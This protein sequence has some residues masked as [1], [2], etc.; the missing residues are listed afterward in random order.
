MTLHLR[1]PLIVRNHSH[2]HDHIVRKVFV[3]CNERVALSILKADSFCD[4]FVKTIKVLH[5]CNDRVGGVMRKDLYSHGQARSVVGRS[6]KVELESHTLGCRTW[7]GD[8]GA[9]RHCRGVNVIHWMSGRT[10]LGT[11]AGH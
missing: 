7:W 9:G 1:W 6:I 11:I 2:I 5:S 3:S 8:V 10:V 4:T